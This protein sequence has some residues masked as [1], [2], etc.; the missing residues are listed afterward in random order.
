M[1]QI[2][3]LNSKRK[4]PPESPQ[5][6]SID[7]MLMLLEKYHNMLVQMKDSGVEH[8]NVTV[9]NDTLEFVPEKACVILGDGATI[10]SEGLHGLNAI[11][12]LGL[13]SK[14]KEIVFEQT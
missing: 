12:A 1:T 5:N 10:I 6:N 13:Q 4:K 11:E 3:D 2:I 7:T 14:L 8:L 9:G